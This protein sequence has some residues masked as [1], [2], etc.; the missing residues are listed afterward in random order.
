MSTTSST[1]PRPMSTNAISPSTGRAY[2]LS[3]GLLSRTYAEASADAPALFERETETARRPRVDLNLCPKSSIPRRLI[4]ARQSGSP[5]RSTALIACLSTLRRRSDCLL[6]Q[7]ARPTRVTSPFVTETTASTTS[8]SRPLEQD[9]AQLAVDRHAVRPR[10]AAR[11]VSLGG[12]NEPDVGEADVPGRH[13]GPPGGQDQLACRRD[14]VAGQAAPGGAERERWASRSM[15]C[16]RP[17]TALY[18]F[19]RR[20]NQEEPHARHP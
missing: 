8:A 16:G 10:S 2:P 4:A 5:V 1:S 3:S 14:L 11:T 15:L 6:H 20:S 18:H 19:R 17:T 7:Q 9:H 12:S 13:G